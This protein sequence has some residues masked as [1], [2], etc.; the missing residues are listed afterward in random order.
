MYAN[1]CCVMTD[2]DEDGDFDLHDFRTVQ[3]QIASR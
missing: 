1:P 2:F 3:L